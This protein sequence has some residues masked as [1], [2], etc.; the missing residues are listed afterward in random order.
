MTGQTHRVGGM[1]CALAG[2]TYL[3]SRGM[4]IANVNPL[5]QLTIIYP[6]A[7]YG[8]TFPDLDHNPDSIPSEDIVSIAVNRLLHLTS[9][10]REARG[11]DLGFPLSLFDAKHR[12][13][14][15]HSDLFLILCCVLSGLLINS[16]VTSANSVIL[17]LVSTG[18]ILGVV[19]HML[20]DLITP[21]GI[22]CLMAVALSKITRLKGLPIKLHLVPYSKFFATGGRW[23]SLV[24]FVMWVVCLI[25]FARIVLG[26]LPY[27]VVFS[28]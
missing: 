24:R 23:E 5:L 26:M 6:F 4:L 27:R 19:S 8:S 10:V 13:W 2:Y 11:R 18:F 7:I 16:Q 25:L 21:S 12:S 14:Q 28:F 22:W 15:T 9:R 1:L 20:L 3:E 17:K